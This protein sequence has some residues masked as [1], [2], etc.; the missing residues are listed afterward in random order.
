MSTDSHTPKTAAT[1]LARSR[2]A[3]ARGMPAVI[4]L[5]YARFRL[6]PGSTTQF[7]DAE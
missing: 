1:S 2:Q 5:M 6:W 7:S 4:T 3:R